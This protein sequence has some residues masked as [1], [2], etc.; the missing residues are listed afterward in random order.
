MIDCL[1]GQEVGKC[2]YSINN[3]DDAQRKRI[4]RIKKLLK[5][6]RTMPPTLKRDLQDFGFSIGDDGKHYIMI[7]FKEWKACTVSKPTNPETGKG[8]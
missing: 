5:N 3:F 2:K 1:F 8:I 6:Y 4:A 7:K